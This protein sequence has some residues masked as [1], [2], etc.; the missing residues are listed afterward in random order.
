[1]E[2]VLVESKAVLCITNSGGHCDNKVRGSAGVR[3]EK[4][5]TAGSKAK[6]ADKDGRGRCR[7]Q[8]EE[9]GKQL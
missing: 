5:Q 2:G 8:V 7:C 4:A 6:L 9:G 3:A 1:M